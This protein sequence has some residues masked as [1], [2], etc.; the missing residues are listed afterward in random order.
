MNDAL[1]AYE[2]CAEVLA[3][4]SWNSFAPPRKVKANFFLRLPD[5]IAWATYQRSWALFEKDGQLLLDRLRER[6][7]IDKFNMENSYR[8]DQML[9]DQIAGRVSSWAIRWTAT[10]ILNNKLTYYPQYSMTKH[11]GFDATGTHCKDSYDSNKA[12]CLAEKALEVNK[13]KAVESEVAVALWQRFNGKLKN[14]RRHGSGF[15]YYTI[16]LPRLLASKIV[17][18]TVKRQLSKIKKSVFGR[19]NKDLIKSFLPPIM[20]DIKHGISPCKEQKQKNPFSGNYPSWDAALKDSAGYDSG[21]IF[22]KVKDAAMAVKKGLAAYER[23]SM[24]FYE[25]DYN[26][27]LLAILLKIA[28]E[29]GGKLSVLDFGGSL[30]S[31]YF[32]HRKILSGLDLHWAIIEQ[33]HFVEFGRVNL[34]DNI[35]K[36]YYTPEEFSR[37]R[38]ADVVLASS[39]L[40]YLEKPYETL[41]C[42][43]QT[44]TGYIIVDR[45]AFSNDPGFITRQNP[46]SIY[47]GISYPFRVFNYCSFIEDMRNMGYDK[48]LD[49]KSFDEAG[50][51]FKGIIFKKNEA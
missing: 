34:E 10:A 6:N 49:F 29:N 3:I 8:Y 2:D 46:E 43:C 40:P 13:E 16:Y 7:L 30:G 37:E 21:L 19:V 17:P 35:L 15:L 38:K 39:V 4:G 32:Q 31:T 20:L 36:F 5:S 45:T 22:E 9:Q 18:D 11:I 41:A 47:P 44:G 51:D 50:F 25:E 24:L 1:N 23:D 48:M 27:P 42:L 26:W 14:G 28:G 33:K 12:L